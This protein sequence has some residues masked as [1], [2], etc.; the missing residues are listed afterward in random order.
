M[1]AGTIAL[2]ASALLLAATAA[3]AGGHHAAAA[4]DYS[5]V[6]KGR[7]AGMRMSNALV[8]GMKAALERGDDVK[9]QSS[10]ARALA[11]WAAAIPGMFPEGSNT[12]P[13]EALPAV[14][15][16]WAG[17]KGK[18]DAYAAAT[19][20]LAAAAAA[21]DKPGFVAALGEVGAGCG[22]CHDG[23]KAAGHH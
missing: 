17:F 2:A 5:G 23:F 9:T 16:D 4:S 19:G 10:A 6:I 11:A 3:S 21:G 14:W 18:A 15:S 1:R 20:K 12:A 22:G 8:G 7:Q 13:S